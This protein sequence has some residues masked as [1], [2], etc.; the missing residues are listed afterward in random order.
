MPPASGTPGQNV[1][2]AERAAGRGQGVRPAAGV[3]HDVLREEPGRVRAAGGVVHEQRVGPGGAVHGVRRR[4]AG[5]TPAVHHHAADEELQVVRPAGRVPPDLE[6]AGPGEGDLPEGGEREVV[7]VAAGVSEVPGRAVDGRRAALGRP[8]SGGFRIAPAAVLLMSVYTFAAVVL[9][10]CEFRLNTPAV[11]PLTFTVPAVA[12]V[13]AV[14]PTTSTWSVP[15]LNVSPPTVSV[16]TPPSVP[17][18]TAP[19]VFTVTVPA[20]LPDPPRVP[21]VAATGRCRWRCPRRCS[22]AARRRRR[23]WCRCRR[24]PR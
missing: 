23:W 4:D 10:A 6:R 1:D 14:S 15:P 17:P 7:A 19:P 20:T 8:G 18:V 21:P 12:T 16:P 3:E 5:V 9:P 2:L 13:S 24:S 11:P 22:R